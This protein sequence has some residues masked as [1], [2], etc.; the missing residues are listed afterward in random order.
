MHMR[1]GMCLEGIELQWRKIDIGTGQE[2]V[3]M[4]GN[5]CMTSL[6]LSAKSQVEAEAVWRREPNLLA[7]NAPFG[8]RTD[9]KAIKGAAPT[10]TSS[11]SLSSSSD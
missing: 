4:A 3:F 5:E 8:R 7:S 10:T 2:W 1:E 9:G 11:Q 6:A